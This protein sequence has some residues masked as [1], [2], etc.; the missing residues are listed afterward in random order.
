MLGSVQL[1][2][3]QFP[4][5][6]N[7]IEHLL[8]LIKTY[9]QHK[10]YKSISSHF[11]NLFPL[12]QKCT[13][14]PLRRQKRRTRDASPPRADPPAANPA[15]PQHSH[16]QRG[17][18]RDSPLLWKSLCS[19]CRARRTQAAVNPYVRLAASKLG[20]TNPSQTEIVLRV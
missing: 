5:L 9:V 18:C 17:S 15:F 12:L 13:A 19:F 1:V 14:L 10:D 7:T 16:Q 2:K 11:L 4:L 6:V 8:S 3:S 20:W